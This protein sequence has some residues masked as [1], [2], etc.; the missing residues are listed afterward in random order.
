MNHDIAAGRQTLGRCPIDVALFRVRNVERAMIVAVGFVKID[1]VNAFRRPLI[2]FVFL[3][4]NWRAAERY[5]VLF[6]DATILKQGHPARRLFDQNPIRH[7]SAGKGIDVQISVSR[8]AAGR[9]N[10]YEKND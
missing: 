4:A 9:E 1:F 10:N 7:G 5:R 8:H 3:G 6:Q 2:A